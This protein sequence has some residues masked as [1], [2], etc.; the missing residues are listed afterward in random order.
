M[1]IFVA[2]VLLFITVTAHWITTFLRLFQAF[3][4]YESGTSPLMFYGDLSQTTEVVKTGLLMASLINGDAMIIYRLWLIWNRKFCVIIFPLCTLIGLTICG[5]GITYQFTQYHIGEDVFLT[6][7]G[8]WITSDC[9]F[10]ICTN[11]YSTCLMIAWKVWSTNKISRAHGHTGMSL[12]PILATLVESAALYTTW[13]ILFFVTY[14]S[15]TNFQFTV[16]DTWVPM[17]GIAYML[18]NVRVGLGWAQSS[19]QSSFASQEPAITRGQGGGDSYSMRPL[20]VN[21]TRVVDN[22]GELDMGILS[23]EYGRDKAGIR[24]PV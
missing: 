13:T 2:T 24:E 23:V 1:P 6:Q 22:D 11:I 14:Q 17:A 4:I 21:I 19:N 20:A 18:I 5:V 7:A 8:R 3:V 9:V 10:T 15:H 12:L 16:V